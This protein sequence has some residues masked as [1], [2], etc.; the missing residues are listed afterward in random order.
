MITTTCAAVKRRGRK[1]KGEERDIK[2]GYRMEKEMDIASVKR[3]RINY[4]SLGNEWK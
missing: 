4:N 2:R 1:G 3:L